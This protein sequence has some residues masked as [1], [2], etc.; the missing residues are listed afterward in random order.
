MLLGVERFKKDH[1]NDNSLQNKDLMSSSNKE[2][3]KISSKYEGSD[4]KEDVSNFYRTIKP[5]HTYRAITR[6]AIEINPTIQVRV[7]TVNLLKCFIQK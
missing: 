4:D 2:K 3:D 6:V 1:K 5:K 7:K